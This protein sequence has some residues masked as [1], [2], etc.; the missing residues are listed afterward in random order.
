[1]HWGIVPIGYNNLAL[2]G[3]NTINGMVGP[4]NFA[5]AGSAFGVFL[6]AKDVKIRQLALSASVTAIF[7]ITEPAIYGINLKYK[8]P[9]YFALVAGGIAGGIT[10][11]AG[12]AALAAGPVGILSIPVFMGQG[13][14][15]FIL[16]IIVAFFSAAIMTFFFGYNPKNE[17]TNEKEEIL[18]SPLNGEVVEL[19]NVPDKVFSTGELGHGLAIIPSDG[20]LVAPVDG[21]IMVAFPTGHAIGM[22]TNNGTEILMHI[23]LETVEL[24]GKYFDVKVKVGQKVSKGDVLVLFDR[25]KILEENY[26]LITPILI[27]NPKQEVSLATEAIAHTGDKL[28]TLPVN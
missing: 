19:K 28:I 13:F 21:E 14:G 23:G 18:A 9:F 10:G 24:N 12:S 16:A 22:C 27:T 26:N 5:Q 2:Y 15:A 3:R 20:K 4:S 1:M 7:S 8:K 6:R 17:E 25:E 11:A